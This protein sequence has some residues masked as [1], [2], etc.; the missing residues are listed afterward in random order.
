MGKKTLD[1]KDVKVIKVTSRIP[2]E[3]RQICWR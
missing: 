2:R 1:D 3:S